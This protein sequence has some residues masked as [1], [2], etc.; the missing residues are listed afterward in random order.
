MLDVDTSEYLVSIVRAC[1]LDKLN[2]FNFRLTIKGSFVRLIPAMEMHTKRR[3]V[4]DE[5]CVPVTL[6]SATERGN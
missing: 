5:N 6:A 4:S 2:I 1:F 3:I